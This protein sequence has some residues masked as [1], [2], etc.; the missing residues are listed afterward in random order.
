MASEKCGTLS[1]KSAALA[2][3]RQPAAE[4]L[5]KERQRYQLVLPRPMGLETCPI[6]L[7]C[8]TSLALG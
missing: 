3:A 7:G 8:S 6:L 1:G 5:R 4:W 2:S